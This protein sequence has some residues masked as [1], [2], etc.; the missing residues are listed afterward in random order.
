MSAIVGRCNAVAP[1]KAEGDLIYG[2]MDLNSN[3]RV[4]G[5]GGTFPISGSVSIA[6]KTILTVCGSASSNT[7][8]IAA[9]TS[10]RIKVVAVSLRTSYSAGAIVPL[11]TDGN[12]GT[13]IYQDLEQA[14]S[15]AVS[16][17]VQAIGGP[18]WICATS[19]GNALYLNPNGQ[20]VYYSIS[21]F[22]DDAT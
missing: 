21:Y 4:T 1:A 14:I 7:A 18:Y 15:G 3:L 10:K 20:T 6:E 17:C 12:G 9:V 8:I 13:T 22:A 19:A 2:S 16:G 5:A 11:L